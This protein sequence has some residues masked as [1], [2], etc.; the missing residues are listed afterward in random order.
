MPISDAAAACGGPGRGLRN[1]SPSRV[2]PTLVSGAFSTSSYVARFIASGSAAFGS[3]Q[4]MSP[5]E[6]P[7]RFTPPRGGS[8]A[9]PSPPNLRQAKA[10]G[11][12]HHTAQSSTC[13]HLSDDDSWIEP[14]TVLADSRT[15]GGR[16][17]FTPVRGARGGRGP[18]KEACGTILG[19]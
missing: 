19:A 14:G 18:P 2:S 5:V 4:S 3:D 10:S 11:A 8:P 6:S 17:H 16:C 1:S 13:Q 15:H 9:G 12:Q 7:A